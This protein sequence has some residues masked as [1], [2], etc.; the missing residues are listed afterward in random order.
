MY[1]SAVFMLTENSELTVI[2]LVLCFL[3]VGGRGT[4]ESS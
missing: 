2:F 1:L 3:G 4:K